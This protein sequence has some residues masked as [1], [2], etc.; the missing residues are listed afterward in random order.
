[1]PTFGKSVQR[2]C[3]ARHF[4]LLLQKTE[5]LDFTWN[6]LA[7]PKF[8]FHDHSLQETVRE[9]NLQAQAFFRLLALCHT[10]MPEEKKEGEQPPLVDI[11]ITTCIATAIIHH[12][13]CP[14]SDDEIG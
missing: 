13:L 6:K 14:I 5:R 3:C 10:V 2:V 12:L 1:M 9:G 11:F 8:I 7:D 4:R